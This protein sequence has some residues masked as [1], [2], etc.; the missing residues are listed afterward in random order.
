MRK[1]TSMTMPVSLVLLE[2]GALSDFEG[3]FPCRLETGRIQ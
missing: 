3:N 2:I 1:I